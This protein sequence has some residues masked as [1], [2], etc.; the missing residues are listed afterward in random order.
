MRYMTAFDSLPDLSVGTLS[1]LSVGKRGT[2]GGS[3]MRVYDRRVD[4]DTQKDPNVCRMVKRGAVEG[5]ALV[6]VSGELQAD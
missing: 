6:S 2:K 4:K 5:V 1:I 3:V